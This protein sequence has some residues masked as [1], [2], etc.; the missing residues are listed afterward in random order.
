[1]YAYTRN[2]IIEV[3]LSHD[4]GASRLA[5]AQ[6]WCCCSVIVDLLSKMLRFSAGSRI[7][8]FEARGHRFHEDGTSAAALQ[9]IT[10]EQ[11]AVCSVVSAIGIDV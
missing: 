10:E 6:C 2:K 8:M 3:E 1:M 9:S 4:R 5:N 7:S 11:V